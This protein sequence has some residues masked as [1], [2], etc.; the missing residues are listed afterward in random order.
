LVRPGDRAKGENSN[1]S[2]NLGLKNL[3]QGLWERLFKEAQRTAKFPRYAQ[4]VAQEKR[5]PRGI[6]SI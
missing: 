5:S 1:S 2:L 6:I 4:K 3:G